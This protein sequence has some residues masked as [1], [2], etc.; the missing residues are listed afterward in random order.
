MTR[1]ICPLLLFLAPLAFGQLESNTVTVTATQN[2]SVQPDQVVF[3][4]SVTSG[5]STS[6]S[7][8]LT[9]VQSAGITSANFTGI[10]S[11]LTGI[12]VPVPT[13]VNQPAQPGGVIAPT[14]QWNFVL[15]APFATMKATITTLTGLEQSISQNNS[16]LSLSFSIQGTQVSQQLQQSQVCPLSDL[17]ASAQSQAQKLA[18]V[19]G[20]SIGAILA[21]SSVT[22]SAPAAGTAI[23]GIV[24]TSYIAPPVCSMTVKFALK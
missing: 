23:L 21:M 5:I 14:I 1:R 15:A 9:A 22:S 16:G 2:L 11:S 8:V 10:S 12:I 4:V 18:N 20:M 24:S 13:P 3:S 19:A 6:L 17:L 7:D